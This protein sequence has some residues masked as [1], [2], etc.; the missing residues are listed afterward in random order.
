MSEEPNPLSLIF[1][2][3]GIHDPTPTLSEEGHI[4]LVQTSDGFLF[5]KVIG[6]KRLYLHGDGFYRETQHSFISFD[7]AVAAYRWVN[8]LAGKRAK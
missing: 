8:K 6:G 3:L 4:G 1:A 5:G 2:V 7:A